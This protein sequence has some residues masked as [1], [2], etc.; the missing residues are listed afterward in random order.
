VPGLRP[1]RNH[2]EVLGVPRTASL[3][4]VRAA[5]RA[6]ARDH[7]PDAGGSPDRMRELNAAW[8]VLGDPVRRAAYDRELQAGSTRPGDATAGRPG[9]AP[10]GE[11]F[12]VDGFVPDLGDM[13]LSAEELADLADG[14]P[15]RDTAQLE[16]WW[17]ILP[18]AILVGSVL[19]F[20]ASFVFVSRGMLAMSAVGFILA[21]G[22]FALAPLQ[23]MRRR[24]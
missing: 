6:A 4:Q 8:R 9:A 16:G 17:A 5:Y 22:L 12:G 3:D 15:L 23:A 2:Y 1:F 24:G 21:L 11:A 13:A 7:H 20:G 19:L 10:T 14:R 18:P